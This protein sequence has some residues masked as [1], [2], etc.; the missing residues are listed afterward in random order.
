MTADSRCG[1][2][3]LVAGLAAHA[4][5]LA[6]RIGEL[7]DAEVLNDVVFSQVTLAF[8]SDERTRAV[9]DYLGG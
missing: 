6:R 3:S 7:P 9:A 8:G 5:E 1:I 4:A 2:A